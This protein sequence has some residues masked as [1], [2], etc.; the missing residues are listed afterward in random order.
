MKWAV[1][2]GIISGMSDGTLQPQAGATCEQTASVAQ[3]FIN[4]V[5]A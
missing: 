5:S 4:V 2:T 1:G 3:R